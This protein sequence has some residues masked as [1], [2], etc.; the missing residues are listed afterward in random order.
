MPQHVAERLVVIVDDL[1]SRVPKEGCVL[2]R[3]GRKQRSHLHDVVD[4]SEC[5]HGG[6]SIDIHLDHVSADATP[7]AEALAA[8]CAGVGAASLAAEALTGLHA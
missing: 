3:D 6:G 4:R 5:K 2:R 7:P 8:F 1:P